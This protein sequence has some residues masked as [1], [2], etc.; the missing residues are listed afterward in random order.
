MWLIIN[1]PEEVRDTD[2]GNMHTKFGE[3]HECGSG[4][5]LVDRQTDTHHNTLQLLAWAK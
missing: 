4:D 5:I 1:V 3:D 2:I